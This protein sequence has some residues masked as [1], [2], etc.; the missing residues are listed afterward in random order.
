[1]DTTRHSSSTSR[2]DAV[3][4]VCV[5]VL[6]AAGAVRADE[7]VE[8]VAEAR[9]ETRLRAGLGV[10]TAGGLGARA[11]G[12]GFGLAGDLGFVLSDRVSLGVRGAWTGFFGLYVRSGGLFVEYAVTDRASLGLGASVV[13]FGAEYPDGTSAMAAVVPLRAMLT[14]G[15][16]DAAA[17][18]REGLS[19]TVELSPGVA[20]QASGGPLPPGSTGPTLPAFALSG[21]I[22]VGYAW[23]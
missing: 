8:G 18:A 7:H 17:R 11:M 4:L 21:A 16:R 2:L 1:M 14:L 23:F 13:A 9:A 20:F 3:R 5:L 15:S 10:V 22:G 6:W 12:Q 19:L